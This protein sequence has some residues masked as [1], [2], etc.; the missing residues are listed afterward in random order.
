MWLFVFI[1]LTYQVDILYNPPIM[2]LNFLPNDP[3]ILKGLIVDLSAQKEA[4]LAHYKSEMADKESYIRELEE[5]VRLLKALRFAARYEKARPASNEVQYRLFD[6]AEMVSSQE[7]AGPDGAEDDQVSHV[8][9]HTRKK[10]GRRPIPPEYPRV[11]VV[12][13]IPEEEKICPCGCRLSRIGE[14]VSEKLDIVPQKIQ[15]IRTIRPKYACRAC[16]GVED[17]GPTVKT[18]PM[19]P[20][21]IPQGIVTPGLLA[22]ILVNKFEDGLPFYRQQKMFDRLGVDISRGVMSAWTLRAAEACGPLIELVHNHIRSG[23]LINMDETPVQVLGEPG[24]KNTSKSYMWVARGGPPDQPAVLFHYDPGRGGRVAQELVGDFQGYLQTDGYAGYN[25]LGARDGL[26]HADCMTHVRRKF[27]EVL[28]GGS[29]KHKAG[30]ASTVVNLI[31][32]LYHLERQAAEQKLDPVA[33]KDLRQERA[34]PIMDKIKAIL[35]ARSQTTPPKSLLGKAVAYALGQWDRLTVYLND[36]LLGPDNNLAENAIRPFAMGRKN[37]LFSGSPSGARASAAIYSLI[38]S[39]KANG[40]NPYE[41]LLTVFEKLP[42]AS[43]QKDLE[44]L[45][46]HHFKINPDVA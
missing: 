3:A 12:H 25:A 16:E 29:S 7:D 20:R 6:E 37:W 28:K 14:E 2:N 36:G 27:M 9:A 23:P 31:G 46:P 11:E 15:V 24:R 5:Q 32:K 17:D 39:A 42:A 33:I 40:L 4:D 8:E 30:T 45:L 35:D 22:Y 13:D 18:A 10:R 34:K 44:A 38:E 1:F 21:I 41:Y 19:P 26:I 43:A